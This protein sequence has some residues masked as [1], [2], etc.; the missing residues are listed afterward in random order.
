MHDGKGLAP[1]IA[2]TPHSFTLDVH[3]QSEMVTC[4]AELTSEGASL[5]HDGKHGASTMNLRHIVSSYGDG[6]PWLSS[7]T[8]VRTGEL[9][10]VLLVNKTVL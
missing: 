2:L 8:C 4:D 10:C 7:H 9:S 3:E 1:V 5:I 6:V